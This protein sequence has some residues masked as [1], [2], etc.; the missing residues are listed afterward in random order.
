[1]TIREP[2]RDLPSGIRGG[3]ELWDSNSPATTVLLSDWFQSDTVISRLKYWNGSSWQTGVLKYW[4][5]SSWQTGVLKYWNGSSW[6]TG[7]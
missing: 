1:M 5:G 7:L 2:Q 4:N 3:S 6:Q